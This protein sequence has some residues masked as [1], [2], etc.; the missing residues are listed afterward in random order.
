MLCSLSTKL[1]SNELQEIGA[2]EETLGVT[3]LAFDC[4]ALDHAPIDKA[5]VERINDLE[6]KLGVALVAVK[7][8]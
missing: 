4:H 1:G 7:P 3:L 5:K 2:L 6:E 8:Q